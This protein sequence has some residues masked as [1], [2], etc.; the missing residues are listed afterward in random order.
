MTHTDR[1]Q[2]HCQQH[3]APPINKLQGGKNSPSLSLPHKEKKKISPVLMMIHM[4]M[5]AD[6]ESDRSTQSD[7][8]TRDLQQ[9]NKALTGLIRSDPFIHVQSLS[10][11][12]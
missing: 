11:W 5:R 6:R 1:E 12:S 9:Y 8:Q 4:V 2:Q 3:G 10:F 7:T